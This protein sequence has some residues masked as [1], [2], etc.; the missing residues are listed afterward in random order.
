MLGSGRLRFIS[1]PSLLGRSQDPETHRYPDESERWH[2]R[3]ENGRDVNHKRSVGYMRGWDGGNTH[4]RYYHRKEYE[5]RIFFWHHGLPDDILF[6]E[7]AHGNGIH[8]REH[9][10]DEVE[11]RRHY[12]VRTFSK[13]VF[14]LN[15]P[16]SRNAMT[17][18]IKAQQRVALGRTTLYV[19]ALLI[20][21]TTNIR[22]YA[23]ALYVWRWSWRLHELYTIPS[24]VRYG[25]V[26]RRR[27]QRPSPSVSRIWRSVRVSPKG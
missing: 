20:T 5:V 19:F 25:V 6:Q 4:G 26:G 18:T 11:R 14:L 2:D 1:L 8:R 10:E 21:G 22:R 24:D 27:R 17:V 16:P 3:K 9:V 23:F 7:Y 13:P 15:P 12:R